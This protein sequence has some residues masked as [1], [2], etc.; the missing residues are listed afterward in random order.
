MKMV[1]LLPIWQ[2]SKQTPLWV[3]SIGQC[4]DSS[5]SNSSFKIENNRIGSS[6]VVIIIF[7]KNFHHPVFMVI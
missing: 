1:S 3:Y 7:Y 6:E 5:P 2:L 4:E